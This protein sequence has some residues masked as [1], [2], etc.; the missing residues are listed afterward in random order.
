MAEGSSRRRR[1]LAVLELEPAEQAVNK[2]VRRKMQ[3]QP[4]V[5]GLHP[6]SRALPLHMAVEA[7]AVLAR[8]SSPMLQADRAVAEQVEGMAQGRTDQ[9]TWAAA[10]VAAVA[11]LREPLELAGQVARVLQYSSTRLTQ[12][13]RR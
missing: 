11:S 8:G 2:G 4:V 3:A 7:V 5:L 1:T 6:L 9:Q 13:R 12:L 10:A